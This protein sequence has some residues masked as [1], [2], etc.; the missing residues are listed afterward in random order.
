MTILVIG[1]GSMGKRRIR[2]MKAMEIEACIIGVDSAAARR[3]EAAGQFGIE[4]F[5]SPEEAAAKHSIDCAF[6]CTAPLAHAALIRGCLTRGWHVFTEINLVADG[7][8]ENIALAEQKGLTLFL[9][10]TPLYRDEMRTV[11]DIV[12]QSGN[13][14]NY[15]YHVGQY[16]PDWHPWESYHSFFVG[17]SR[18]GGC[19]ELL[20]IELPWMCRAFG[21]I[22]DVHAA[23]S[24]L[25]GLDIAYR[26]SYLIQ[27]RHRNGNAGI[28]AVDVA[29]R[30]AVRKLEVYNED[31]YLAWE[32]TPQS[33][34][35]YDVK[36][37]TEKAAA[38][39]EYHREPGYSEFVNEC[40]YMNEIREFFD[41]IGGKKPQYTMEDDRKLLAWID[42][43]ENS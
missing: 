4:C 29:C 38:A 28:L 41:V 9:S 34:R 20:A 2:L 19:R 17:D 16:L 36:A 26:D 22:A 6:V 30:K 7:Y 27:I 40:A 5:A 32:G 33:L 35:Q 10:S 15:L 37:G 31:I 1:L 25:T 24:R 13:A 18:T 8:E 39:G 11:T 3:G 23:S 14:V 42:R 12:Q 21:D 43:I